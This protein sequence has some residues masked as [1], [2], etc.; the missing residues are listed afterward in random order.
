MPDSRVPASQPVLGMLAQL[1][2][3]VADALL[4]TACPCGVQGRVLCRDCARILLR[5]PHRVDE[6]LDAL[7]LIAP[8]GATPQAANLSA[9]GGGAPAV[10]A[11]DASYLPRFPVL[12]LGTYT[13][14]MQDAV[15]AFKNGGHIALAD[16]FAP[17]LAAGALQLLDDEEAAVLVPVPSSAAAV[18]RRGER[19][20]LTLA[21][22]IAVITGTATADC[23]RT[24]GSSQRRKS[25]RDRR[26]R[27]QMRLSAFA[28]V[29]GRIPRRAILI[30]DVATTGSTLAAAADALEAA[31]AEVIGALTIAAADPIRP[32]PDSP[33][34]LHE[35]CV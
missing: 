20:T 3:L 26:R 11:G 6:R 16:A 24:G 25:S 29:R 35:E 22:R 13:S 30:D 1:L 2:E 14:V 5:S 31:G 28:R 23:L 4:P 7:Q 12:A 32:A 10:P 21:E 8:S 15:L 9:P 19:H 27:Q 17:P 18:R 33:H 34:D